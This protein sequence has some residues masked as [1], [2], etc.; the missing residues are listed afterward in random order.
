MR[1]RPVHQQRN[2]YKLTA[3]EAGPL[4]WYRSMPFLVRRCL[5]SLVLRLVAG[6]GA[7]EAGR[8]YHLE[9]APDRAAV[10]HIVRDGMNKT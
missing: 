2:A 10:Q 4:L 8:L 1:P 5:C 6:M 9:A 7:E 3:E